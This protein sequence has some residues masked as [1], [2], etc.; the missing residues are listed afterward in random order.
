M[1]KE[2]LSDFGALILRIGLAFVFFYFGIDKFIHLEA[3]AAIIRSF[4]FVPVNATIFT[5]F[6]GVL[7]V[8][9]GTFLVLGLFSRITAGIASVMLTSIILVFWFKQ[10]I[11][12]QRDIGLLAIALFLLLNG[13]GRF[14]FDRYVRVKGIMER[15]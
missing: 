12:L 7:E 15:N 13:G 11:F 14:G 10:H 1:K 8:M 9:V 3:N 6:N 4:A 2:A 5:I